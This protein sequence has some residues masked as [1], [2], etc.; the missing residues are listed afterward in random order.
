MTAIPV[1]IL[2]R[3]FASRY[4]RASTW[5]METAPA[6]CLRGGLP[7]RCCIHHPALLANIT[8]KPSTNSAASLCASLSL[9]CY[10]TPTGSRE[11]IARQSGLISGVGVRLIFQKDFGVRYKIMSV[12][13]GLIL[14]ALL[15]CNGFWVDNCA[16]EAAN[17]TEKQDG[18]RLAA[19]WSIT[20]V[21]DL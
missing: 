7:V 6:R 15:P 11:G 19:G 18:V 3:L 10:W 4:G 1:S 16:T 12:Q 14:C 8:I 17:R 5:E 9:P 2:Q 20:G 21:A 13:T